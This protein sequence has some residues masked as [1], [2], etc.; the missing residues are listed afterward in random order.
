MNT[1]TDYQVINDKAG[2]PAFVVI[3]YEDFRHIREEIEADNLTLSNEVV[4]KTVMEDK[5]L[6]CAWREYRN[7][8][9]EAMAQRMGMASG[10]YE[11]V[12]KQ[13]QIPGKYRKAA[14][15]ILGTDERLLTDE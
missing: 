2:N 13:K 12:E 11:A 4:G 10:E 9:K 7:I 14:A 8:P 6:L 1:L 5:S 3:P 15:E